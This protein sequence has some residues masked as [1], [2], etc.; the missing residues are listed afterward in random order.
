M[1][2]NLTTLRSQLA[3]VASALALSLVLITG[4]VSTPT[5]AHA[6]NATYVGE[7]A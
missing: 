3:A 4:T 6:A 5:T 7:M 1:M 2:Q